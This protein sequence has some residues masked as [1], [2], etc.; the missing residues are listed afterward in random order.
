MKIKWGW[1]YK[2]LSNVWL[3]LSNLIN[4]MVWGKCPSPHTQLTGTEFFIW[5]EELVAPFQFALLGPV[6]RLAI[7][8]IVRDPS[9]LTTSLLPSWLRCIWGLWCSGPCTKF[10]RSLH[11][12]EFLRGAKWRLPVLF[13]GLLTPEDFTSYKVSL[14][15]VPGKNLFAQ[16]FHLEAQMD[17][18]S[19]MNLFLSSHHAFSSFPPTTLFDEI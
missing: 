13:W 3:M 5:N 6:T 15:L 18:L 7:N 1:K 17:D 11:F 16:H 14:S 19:I 8:V 12:P 4:H 10:N 9:L 2:F